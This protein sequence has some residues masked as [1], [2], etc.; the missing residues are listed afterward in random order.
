MKRFATFL[1]AVVVASP[2][3][4]AENNDALGRRVGD[5][6]LQDYR[7]A[8][9]ALSEITGK[10]ATV[11]AFLGTECPLA[12]LYGPR[13][14]ELAEKYASHGRGLR[15]HRRQSPGLAQRDRGVRPHGRHQVPAAERHWQCG[16]RC[17]R[18]N[19]HARSLR[20]RQ[21]SGGALL[22]AHRRSLRRR[23][24]ARQG[25]RTIISP[26]HSTKCWPARPSR[27]PRRHGGLPDWP[28]ARGNRGQSA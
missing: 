15:R 1:I 20:A 24:R 7:G 11:I 2:V 18:R 5:F 9:H 25:R 6:K 13:L 16:R 19:A 28:R 26:R 22:G 3:V 4:K 27:R 23:L 14:A 8:D 10:Q 17:D 21:G 12:K